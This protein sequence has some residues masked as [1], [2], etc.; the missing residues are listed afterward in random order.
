MSTPPGKHTPAA[1]GHASLPSNM[2]VEIEVLLEL[3]E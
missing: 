1:V 3:K 2:A